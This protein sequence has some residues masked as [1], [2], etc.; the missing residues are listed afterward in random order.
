MTFQNTI[1]S[2]HAFG[3]LTKTVEKSSIS[4]IYDTISS[5]KFFGTSKLEKEIKDELSWEEESIKRA[6]QVI[7]SLYNRYKQSDKYRDW[8]HEIITKADAYGISYDAN[9]I[10]YAYL[11]DTILEKEENERTWKNSLY[12]DYLDSRL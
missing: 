6:Q 4:S 7:L 2:P 5:L 10:D 12:R 9:D 3:S 11:D 8:Q 1:S